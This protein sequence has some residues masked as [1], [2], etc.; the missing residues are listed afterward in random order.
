MGTGL[1]HQT[2]D[3]E[4]QTPA[5]RGTDVIG[6]AVV[7]LLPVGREIPRTSNVLLGRDYDCAVRSVA[8]TFDAA[9]GRSL[10]DEEAPHTPGPWCVS[11]TERPLFAPE[12]VSLGESWFRGVEFCG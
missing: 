1:Q 11:E 6:S 9:R 8:V 5:V 10:K 2:F 4:A 12:G 7:G 3:A